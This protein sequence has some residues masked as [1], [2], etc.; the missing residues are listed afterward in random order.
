[1]NNFGVS[2]SFE[3]L[4]TLCK[5]PGI[6]GREHQFRDYVS[7]I[8]GPISDE[9][10]RTDPMGNLFAVKRGNGQAPRSIMLAAHMDEIGFIV[11]F[12]TKEGFIY[13]QPLGGFDPRVL[14][15]HRVTVH[16]KVGPLTGVFGFKP[17]HFTTP[18]ER[19]K[20]VPLTDLFIDIGYPAEKVKEMVRIGDPI[21]MQSDLIEM[22][23]LY[24]GKTLDDRVG[25]Y[26]M[27]EA[28]RRF[29]QSADH[30][31]A[32]ATV[33]E[34]IGVRGARTA[35]F[36]L[37]PHIGIALDITIAADIPGVDEKDHC[38]KIGNGV[39]IKV[40]DSLSVSH[41]GLYQFFCELAERFEIPHQYEV[42]P[43]GGT[44]A[45]AMQVS[46]DGIPVITLSI[47]C[48]YTHTVA[49]AV[50][51]DDIEATIRLLIA[52]LEHSHEFTF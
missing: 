1:V 46:R 20:V 52:F 19:N 27:L 25:V 22:G 23:N 32:V 7:G 6:P 37:E 11:R 48:R 35:S 42:L 10:L 3:L 26:V 29:K 8:L 14:I 24:S 49:E 47:P 34:E 51:K 13:V 31:Y 12:I 39:G 30:I 40:M 4:Q 15:A 45:G 33:Q 28:F 5:T 50:H 18:E 38:V 16:T 36:G 43:S 44:D 41:Y 9:P 2:M 17:T 21:T